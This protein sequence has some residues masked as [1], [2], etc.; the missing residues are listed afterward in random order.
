M[1]DPADVAISEDRIHSSQVREVFPGFVSL[2]GFKRQE[3]FGL[4]RPLA[5]TSAI[6]RL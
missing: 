1:N 3:G 6:H 2:Q 4:D 5:L